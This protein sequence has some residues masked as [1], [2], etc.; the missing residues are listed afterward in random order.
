MEEGL[1]DDQVAGIRT[2]QCRVCT[3]KDRARLEVLR[4]EAQ[5]WMRWRASSASAGI[6][7][8]HFKA[9]VSAKRRAQLM[10]GPPRSSS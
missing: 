2:G 5:A 9:H 6:A 7:H 1:D 10:C 4:M 3:H 8:R